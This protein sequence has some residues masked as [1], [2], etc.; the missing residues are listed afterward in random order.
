MLSIFQLINLLYKISEKY[1]LQGF[2]EIVLS[3]QDL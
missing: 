2:V 1:L 3:N